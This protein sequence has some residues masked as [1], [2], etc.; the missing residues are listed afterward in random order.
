MDI[1]FHKQRAW[2]LFYDFK[3]DEALE[4]CENIRD[5]DVAD[6]EI[7]YLLGCCYGH[8]K[9][10]SDAV[11]AFQESLKTKPNAI[12]TLMAL[13]TALT[14]LGQIDEAIKNY[15]FVLSLKPDMAAA[16]CALA[17][18]LYIHESFSEAKQHYEK[19]MSLQPDLAS[20]YAGMA[21][22]AWTLDRDPEKALKYIT[23]AVAHSPENLSYKCQLGDALLNV[24]RNEESLECF[25]EVL[26]LDPENIRAIG[27]I[28]RIHSFQGEYDKAMDKI[29]L[30]RKKEVYTV[31]A[32]NAFANICKSLGNCEESVEYTKKLLQ[33]GEDMDKRSAEAVYM[34]LAR[35][36]DSLGQYEEAWSYFIKG[37]KLTETP[38]DAVAHRL[39]TENMKKFYSHAGMMALPKST[40]DTKR[41]IFIVGMPR[42]GT[43]LVEQILAAHPKVFGGGELTYMSDVRDV[44]MQRPG[45]DENWPSCVR[46][47]K[48]EDLNRL[49]GIYLEHLHGLSTS[50][51]RVTDKMPHNF[52]ELGLIQMLFPQAHIIHCNRDPMDTCVSIFQQNFLLEHDYSKS[53]Y[54]IGVHYHQYLDLM[55]HWRSHLSI[56]FLDVQYEELVDNPENIVRQMLEH[57]NLEWYD[58]CMDFHKVKRQVN[59][60]SFD[61]VRQPIYKK[62]VQRWRNYEPHLDEL[63]AGL[64]R[65]F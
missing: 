34:H 1:T 25:S 7:H 11:S 6:S 46:E 41:P 8:E 48:Q 37:N 51:E 32:A 3:T 15:E 19:A 26:R 33:R 44:I 63:K 49:A 9:Q 28:A 31:I 39:R 59:T 30:L 57:C 21:S 10:Y 13:G 40:I 58:G 43:S 4:I 61:Q 27:S 64:K 2:K 45:A 55:S 29:D 5:A 16:H 35:V 23:D 50:A 36:L 20:A 47:L 22:I 12:V 38:Y 62:S 24:Q 65:G 53:L 54:H 42:S 18:V 14:K 17:D 52:F 60:A 56:P